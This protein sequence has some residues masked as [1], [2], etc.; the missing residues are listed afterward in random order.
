MLNACCFKQL[1]YEQQSKY[2]RFLISIKEVQYKNECISVWQDVLCTVCYKHTETVKG[3]LIL[4]L[5]RSVL[6][7]Q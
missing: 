4:R 3:Y 1:I 2:V 7:F 5:A 6:C